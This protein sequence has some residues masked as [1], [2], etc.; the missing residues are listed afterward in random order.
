MV[1]GDQFIVSGLSREAVKTGREHGVQA[2]M[3]RPRLRR[4]EKSRW[5]MKMG[6]G[7]MVSVYQ[8]SQE[9]GWLA[10]EDQYVIRE[11]MASEC[12]NES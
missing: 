11:E 8:A 6:S 5:L 1:C 7:G 4:L 2:G 3:E 12:V 9:R 10:W